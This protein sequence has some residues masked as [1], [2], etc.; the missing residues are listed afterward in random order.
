MKIS[1]LLPFAG[2]RLSSTTSKPL[3]STAQVGNGALTIHIGVAHTQGLRDHDEDAFH[4]ENALD[5]GPQTGVFIAVYDGHSSARGSRHASERLHEIFA[6]QPQLDNAQT[7][8]RSDINIDPSTIESAFV[9]AFKQADKEIIQNAQSRGER[10]GSTAVCALFLP[11]T[12]LFVAHV[13][14]SRAILGRSGSTAV[15]LTQDH[16]PAS[17]PHEKA[18]IEALGG[19]IIYNKD[20]VVSNPEADRGVISRLNMSRAL[21]DADHK[22]PRKLV[23][24]T[25][26]VIHVQLVPKQDHFVV[27]GTDGLFDVM[28][29]ADVCEKVEQ[30]RTAVVRA[31]GGGGEVA[32]TI[33]KALV[34]ESLQRGASDNVTAAVALLQWKEG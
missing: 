29:A 24:N 33:A 1:N 14:D 11:E 30:T 6:A 12:D 21:G 23:E 32:S 4:V 18:R 20:R 22:Y 17:D 28:S 13:G 34:N 26:S 9:S 8:S 27:L 16:K 2:A 25:P 3:S 10:Y 7:H 15:E 19:Q 31:E 5:L